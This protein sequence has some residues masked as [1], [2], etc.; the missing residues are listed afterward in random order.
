MQAIGPRVLVHVVINMFC[1]ELFLF[2]PI[3]R[4]GMEEHPMFSSMGINYQENS[5]MYLRKQYNGYQNMWESSKRKV[6]RLYVKI[7]RQY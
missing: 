5:Q 1:F 2:Q 4:Y 6:D 7:E 3:R